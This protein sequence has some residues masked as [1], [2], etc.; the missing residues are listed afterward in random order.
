MKFE[1]KN[2]DLS[3]IISYSDRYKLCEIEYKDKMGYNISVEKFFYQH[4]HIQVIMQS[5][6]IWIKTNIPENKNLKEAFFHLRQAKMDA[7]DFNE[8]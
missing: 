3:I 4:A 7:F 5:V 6:K 8:L 1:V 2:N